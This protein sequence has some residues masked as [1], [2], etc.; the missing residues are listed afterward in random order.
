MFFKH[1]LLIYFMWEGLDQKIIFIHLF[2]VVL[3]FLCNY[4]LKMQNIPS[5][6]FLCLFRIIAI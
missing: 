5:K 3:I 4:Y 2:H 6:N 1:L